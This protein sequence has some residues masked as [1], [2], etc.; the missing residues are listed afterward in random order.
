MHLLVI[1]VSPDAITE[2]FFPLEEVRH[3]EGRKF[4]QTHA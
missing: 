1:V 3:E 4:R 2:H